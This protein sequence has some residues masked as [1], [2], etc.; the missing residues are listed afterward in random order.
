MKSCD[1]ES[2]QIVRKWSIVKE[3][4]DIKMSSMLTAIISTLNCHRV[5][6]MI[7]FDA[8]R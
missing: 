8:R 1:N 5:V 3:T 4:I 7:Y 6:T 2:D